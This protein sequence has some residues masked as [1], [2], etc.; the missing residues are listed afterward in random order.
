MFLSWGVPS[1]ELRVVMSVSSSLLSA[2][3]LPATVLQDLLLVSGSF[4]QGTGQAEA[5]RVP[6]SDVPSGACLEADPAGVPG[7]STSLFKRSPM[8]LTGQE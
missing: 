2:K 6:A 1:S 7:A 8:A 3:G 4:T 5:P